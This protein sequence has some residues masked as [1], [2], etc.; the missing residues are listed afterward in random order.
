MSASYSPSLDLT[1]TDHRPRPA[2]YLLC[3]LLLVAS[4]EFAW[5]VHSLWAL[6]VLVFLIPL[7][8]LCMPPPPVP[9]TLLL[10]PHTCLLRQGVATVP[11][12]IILLPGSVLLPWVVVLH[13]RP[14]AGG[15][16][17]YLWLW[18]ADLGQDRFRDLRRWLL[19]FGRKNP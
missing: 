13:W 2:W 16:R 5:R 12:S 17:R 11:A 15:G 6:S 9:Q 10:G 1:W 19:V 4:G 7:A 18:A 3:L 8:W 14:V